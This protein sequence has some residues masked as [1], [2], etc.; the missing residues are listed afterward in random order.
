MKVGLDGRSVCWGD[1]CAASHSHFTHRFCSW[2]R[3]GLAK[4]QCAPL[5][6]PTTLVRVLCFAGFSP[7]N[8][9]FLQPE[10]HPDW[11][12][13]V[14]VSAVPH[15]QATSHHS[16]LA[17]D[18]QQSSIRFLGN[19]VLSL[20]DCGG[21]DAF[22]ESYFDSQRGTIFPNVAVLIYVFDIESPDLEKDFQYYEGCIDALGQNSPDS[23]IFCL[24]HKMDIAPPESRQAVFEERAAVIR[25]RSRGRKVE[26][27]AT[28]IWDE[29][30]YKA[31]SS[32][33]YSLIPNVSRLE[34]HLGEFANVC[35][36]DEVVVFE[37]A[38]FLVIAHTSPREHEDEHR[39]E[40]I[41]NIVK[42]FKLTCSK[43]GAQFQAMSVGGQDFVAFVDEFTT[44]TYVMVVTSGP[45]QRTEA[46]SLNIEIAR[47]HFERLLQQAQ[48]APG[49]RELMAPAQGAAAAAGN[50]ATGSLASATMPSSLDAAVTA[51]LG[52]SP[53][54]LSAVKAAVASEAED[55]TSS[56]LSLDPL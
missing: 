35:S 13:P 52:S 23:R 12:L 46:V 1:C 29:T 21:Q 17:V 19:L 11:N 31:W 40:K 4:H 47:Q 50:T 5:F 10:A 34:K 20:W 2:A 14:C 41:S 24:V 38:T 25:N 18:V 56:S 27:F 28:S 39:F 33:V 44:N 7:S 22:Y 43:C 30:L 55:V 15:G 32:I 53:G 42:Q 3:A 36:A 48:Q 26:C 45:H 51:T 8:I 9:L 6:S 37:R 54:D 16:L 49:A